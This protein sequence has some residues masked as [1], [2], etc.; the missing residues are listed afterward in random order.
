V[1]AHFISVLLIRDFTFEGY[2]EGYL[3][4]LLLPAQKNLLLARII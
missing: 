1:K 3:L 2:L 4:L